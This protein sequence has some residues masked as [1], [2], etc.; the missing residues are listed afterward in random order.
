VLGPEVGVGLCQPGLCGEHED[1]RR[2]VGHAV[3][4]EL[5]LGAQRVVAGRV[6]DGEPGGEQRV[7]QVHEGVAP[8]RDADQPRALDLEAEV[9]GAPGVHLDRFGDRVARRGERLGMRGIEL[10]VRPALAVLDVL[11]QRLG[12]LARADRQQAH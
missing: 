9:G 4:R 1:D 11:A 5:G 8:A 7:W 10:D 2:G 6:E 3:Q 12:R